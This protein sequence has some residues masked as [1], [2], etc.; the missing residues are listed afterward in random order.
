MP[1]RRNAQL[2]PDL[3]LPPDFLERHHLVYRLYLGPTF[4]L[5]PP[6]PGRP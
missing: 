6:T 5:T 3:L 4:A 1:H 2:P